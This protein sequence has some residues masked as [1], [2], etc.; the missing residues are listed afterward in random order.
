MTDVVLGFFLLGA[1]LLMAGGL[2]SLLWRLALQEEGI[3][4]QA[5]VYDW[6]GLVGELRLMA[7]LFRGS[8]SGA[9]ESYR[10]AARF[11]LMLAGVSLAAFIVSGILATA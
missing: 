7:R 2:L 8:S 11:C 4:L 1:A 6:P 10:R 5:L 9:G 3:A